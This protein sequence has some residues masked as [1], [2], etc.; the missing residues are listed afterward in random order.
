M[1]SILGAWAVV[2]A[3]GCFR[4]AAPDE[5][6]GWNGRARDELAAHPVFA[7]MPLDRRPLSD[8]A[9]LWIFRRCVKDEPTY[10]MSNGVALPIGGGSSC[11]FR[12][13][14]IRD[15]I[16]ARVLMAGKC[17]SYPELQPR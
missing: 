13:F 5:L 6:D 1:R 2:C 4:G 14:T 16:V 8:G 3:I 15:G 9:E 12:E 11:C 7:T 17:G 10:V